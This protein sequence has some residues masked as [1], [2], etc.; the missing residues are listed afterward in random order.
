MRINMDLGDFGEEKA[1]KYLTKNN[2]EIIERNFRCKQGEIDIIAKDTSKNELV[3]IEVK[4][5]SSFQYGR[6]SDAVNNF[7]KRHIISASKYYIYKNNLNSSYIRFDVIEI[8]PQDYS[9]KINHLKQI[10]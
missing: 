6:P 1:C 4:T 5:R 8:F 3:F 7:K 9:F 2:Y 10:L